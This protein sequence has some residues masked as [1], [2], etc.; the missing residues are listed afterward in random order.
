MPSTATITSFYSFTANTKARASQVNGNFDLFRGHI[1][2]I[3]PNTQ[4]AISATYDLGSSEYRWKNVYLPATSGTITAAAGDWGISPTMLSSSFNTS[5]SSPIAGTTVTVTTIGRPVMYGLF[6]AA[7]AGSHAYVGLNG[8]TTTSDVTWIW[9]LMRDG[10]TI[11]TQQISDAAGSTTSRY[12]SPG[13][14]VFIDTPA[15]GT[16]KYS[17]NGYVSSGSCTGANIVRA[18]AFAKEF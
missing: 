17:L 9:T 6:P 12:R 14:F 16:Y 7:N 4:T 2:P 11:A 8:M 15:A 1:I 10:A 18:R 13:E 5:A 3:D